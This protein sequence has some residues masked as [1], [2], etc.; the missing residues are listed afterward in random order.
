MNS[1]PLKIR[2]FIITLKIITVR[3]TTYAR[4]V[5]YITNNLKRINS[6]KIAHYLVK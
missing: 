4:I 2:C 3:V 5:Y 1:Y 6:V